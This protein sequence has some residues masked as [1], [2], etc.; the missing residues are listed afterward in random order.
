MIGAQHTPDRHSPGGQGHALTCVGSGGG[1]LQGAPPTS[2]FAQLHP[3]ASAYPVRLTPVLIGLPRH[4]VLVGCIEGQRQRGQC[5]RCGTGGQGQ[6]IILSV[7]HRAGFIERPC[8]RALRRAMT[9]TSKPPGLAS[10]RSSWPRPMPIL[11]GSLPGDFWSSA[12]SPGGKASHSRCPS[13]CPGGVMREE[14]P[15]E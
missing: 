7:L 9:R 6:G 1:R 12:A 8:A 2:A 15:V 4:E 5:N 11:P 14:V 10:R 3:G 13:C